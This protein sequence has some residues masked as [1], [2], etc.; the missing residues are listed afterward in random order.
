MVVVAVNETI[1][2][3]RWIV[4][5]DAVEVAIA[6]ERLHEL[7]DVK[8]PCHSCDPLA[9][10]LENF[11]V[12]CTQCPTRCPC[13]GSGG[14]RL[15][16]W[17]RART[18]RS[19]EFSQDGLPPGDVWVYATYDGRRTERVRTRVSSGGS[20]NVTLNLPPE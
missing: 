17:S 1:L 15:I 2:Y 16:E 3:E 13:T 11:V 7:V 4:G 19:G 12:L 8:R 9:L 20:T 18:N 14:A 5:Q 6:N 10:C